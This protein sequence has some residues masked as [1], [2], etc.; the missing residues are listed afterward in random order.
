MKTKLITRE[1]YNKL[2]AEHDHLWHE[3]R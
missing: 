2:K 1:G 3:K